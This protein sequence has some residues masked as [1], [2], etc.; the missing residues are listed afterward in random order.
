M[1]NSKVIPFVLFLVLVGFI[2]ILS[3][4]NTDNPIANIIDTS[5]EG[6]FLGCYVSK[7]AKDTY[8]IKLE[9]VSDGKV[10]GMLAFNN[11]E[12]DSSSGTFEGTYTDGILLGE[13][14]FNSEGMES[15]RQ[16]IF[17]N[18]GDSFIQG[19]GEVKSEGDKEVFVDLNNITYEPSLNFIK[20][21]TCLEYFSDSY[22]SITF[23]HDPIFHVSRS[24][25]TPTID[26]K[27]NAKQTGVLIARL[28]IPKAFLPDTNFSN[29]Y[30]TVGRSSDVNQIKNCLVADKNINEKSAGIVSIDG[31]DFTK[32]TFNDAGAGNFSE[33]T[34]YRGIHD[35][36]CYVIEHTIRSTNIDNY[37]ADQGIK[38]FDKTIVQK[39]LEN[40][41]KSMVL[42]VNGD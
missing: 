18:E 30:L 32:F 34:S 7:L 21:E 8:V 28:S 40:I 4:R 23:Y 41:I 17:K 31:N 24:T 15:N 1:K 36:E 12:K 6:E 42:L 20:N 5:V 29:A 16:V 39:E 19:F 14:V 26:W 10:S 33:T 3:F 9:N 25:L 13:Y 27:L 2:A 37:S 35:G 11:F 38:E 22:N